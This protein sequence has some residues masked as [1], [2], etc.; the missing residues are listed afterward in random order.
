[1]YDYRKMTPQERA[2]IMDYRRRLRQLLLHSPPHWSVGLTGQYLISATCY[3]HAPIIGKR[4]ERMTACESDMLATC[5]E[6]SGRI[7]AWCILPQ[8][9]SRVD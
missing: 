9:L 1:M 3:E 4:P 7:Y 5:E 6:H 8:S 2:Q